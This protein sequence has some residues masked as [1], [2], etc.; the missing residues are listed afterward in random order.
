VEEGERVLAAGGAVVELSSDVT[1]VN[2]DGEETVFAGDAITMTQMVVTLTLRAD[3]TWADGEPL[4]AG[5]SR[6]SYE[7]AGQLDDAALHRRVDRTAS[8]EVKDEQTVVWTGVPGYQDSYYMLNFYHPLPRHVL[9]DAS[10]EELMAMDEVH[11][12]PLGWGAFMVESWRE[13][14]SVSLVR[15]PHYF[16]AS[17]G[18]PHLDR[19]TF[20]FFDAPE[21]AVEALLAGA[22]DVIDERL[23]AGTALASLE[24]AGGARLISEP[25]SEW[26][27]LDFGVQPARWSG[28]T[29][30]FTAREVRHAIAHCVD[31]E[32][33]AAAAFAHTEAAVAHS[34]VMGRHPLYAGDAL[35]PWAH[36]PAAG[37]AMLEEAGWQD[38]DGDGIR[39]AYGVAGIASGTVFSTTL[40]TTE[41]DAARQRAAEVLQQNLADCGVGVSVDYLPPDVFYADG[42][43]GPI[44]GRQFDLA[45]FSWLNGLSA[46]CEVYLS[47][48][49]PDE[50]NWWATSN[51]PGYASEAYDAACRTALEALYGTEAFLDAHREAQRIFSQDL[52]VLPLYLV[53]R[54]VAVR[55]RVNGIV[56]DPSQQ[57]VFWN[58]ESIDVER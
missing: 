7:L 5:D 30:F 40:L 25:S 32:G 58:V 37:Q 35:Q 12:R 38:T 11:R 1:V 52:P 3:L 22:C 34:Y 36:D 46:P 19:V 14:N 43:D 9:G 55:P 10:V 26:E 24:E 28:R 48:Q 13:G 4:T 27:H 44:F 51:N 20:R 57:T 6:F 39:E 23:T 54:T 53:P 47:S 42:P 15:N 2:A 18:L 21:A 45:L 33:I 17:E 31:R 50:Q 29:P 49:I 41:G 8:Y 56:L 16:R